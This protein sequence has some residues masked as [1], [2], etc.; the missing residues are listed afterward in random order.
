MFSWNKS[1]ILA[2]IKSITTDYH[3]FSRYRSLNQFI[4]LYGLLSNVIDYR[5]HR[6]SMH[7]G[8]RQYKLTWLLEK[9]SASC[10]RW[11]DFNLLWNLSK[12][13][14]KNRTFELELVCR[15]FVRVVE[16]ESKNEGSDFRHMPTSFDPLKRAAS[17]NLSEFKQLEL[18]RNWVK[19]TDARADCCLAHKTTCFWTFQP[20]YLFSPSQLLTRPNREITHHVYVKRQTRICTAWPSFLF[21]CRLLLIISTPK[22]VISRNFSSIRIVLSCFYL[23]IFYFEKFSTWIWRLPLAV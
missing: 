11:S 21:T 6:L 15:A 20:A 17:Q 16:H 12:R 18:P 23:L 8:K 7:T 14:L 4:N 13:H 19:H 1:K 9:G 3:N 5:L 10:K 22:L 2:P